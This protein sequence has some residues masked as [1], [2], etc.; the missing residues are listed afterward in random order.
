MHE[1]THVSPVKT[2][3]S[4]HNKLLLAKSHRIVSFTSFL[5]INCVQRPVFF[6]DHLPIPHPTLASPTPPTP[7][8]TRS[9]L[10]RL[11]KIP[12]LV[13][14]RV[15]FMTPQT[16]GGGAYNGHLGVLLRQRSTVCI[17]SP[18]SRQRYHRSIGPPRPHISSRAS[19]ATL[20]QGYLCLSLSPP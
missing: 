17:R 6:A 8:P 5:L 3:L 12:S 15:V 4:T 1:Y 2:V 9:P 13:G 19:A 18:C 10:T 16:G 11:V 7:R 20:E 14:C